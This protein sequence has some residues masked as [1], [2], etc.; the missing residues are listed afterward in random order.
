MAGNRIESS[1]C[2]QKLSK[3][4]SRGSSGG[5]SNELETTRQVEVAELAWMGTTSESRERNEA[6]SPTK[7][8]HNT[9]SM[10]EDMKIVS[11]FLC[12]E[13]AVQRVLIHFQMSRCLIKEEFMVL[14]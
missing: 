3:L 10:D 11:L 12:L 7:A 9:A 13:F 14:K 5:K 1:L 2:I 8:R 4:F 6:D